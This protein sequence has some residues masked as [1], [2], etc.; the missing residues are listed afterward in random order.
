MFFDLALVQDMSVEYSLF[1]IISFL[2]CTYIYYLSMKC[3]SKLRN[4][5]D[6]KTA[7]TLLY[8]SYLLVPM[9]SILGPILCLFFILKSS[10]ENYLKLEL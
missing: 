6:V 1:I 4:S 9:G 2:F 5:D 10:R 3:A 7:A 8:I